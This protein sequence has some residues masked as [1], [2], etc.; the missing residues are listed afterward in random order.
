M[1][2]AKPIKNKLCELRPGGVRLFYFTYINHQ[3]VI[4]HGYKKQGM[5]TPER[6]IAIAMKRMQ[7]LLEE[8]S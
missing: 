4:L 3:F 6:E 7:E 2:H 8:D 5:K 1:P